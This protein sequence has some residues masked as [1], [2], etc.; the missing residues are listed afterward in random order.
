M[1]S[2]AVQFTPF[3]AFFCSTLSACVISEYEK[4]ALKPEVIA[5]N[6]L[7]ATGSITT[8]ACHM[9]ALSALGAAVFTFMSIQDGSSEVLKVAGKVGGDYKVTRLH[10]EFPTCTTLRVI[11]LYT[12]RKNTVVV[13]SGHD[14]LLSAFVDVT[15]I[16]VHCH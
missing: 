5:D 15:T 12:T 13:M 8:W 3:A 2:T 7:S 11:M 10:V 6:L 14:V 9:L 4:A 16:T 1:I